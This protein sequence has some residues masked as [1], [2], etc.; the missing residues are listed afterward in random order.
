M[1]ALNMPAPSAPQGMMW[2][3][4]VQENYE[5]NGFE[6][7]SNPAGETDFQRELNLDAQI[8][9][10]EAYQAAQVRHREEQERRKSQTSRRR[11][12]FA[13]ELLLYSSNRTYQDVDCMWY[14]REELAEFK[15]ERK[16]I[17]K[18]LKKA[19]FNL[20][21]V[22]QSG[23]YCL[24]GYEAYFSME[25]N[26]A[27]KYSRTLVINVVATEQA[28][29]RKEGVYFDDE[30]MRSACSGSSQ[31]AL[32]NALLLG[33]NDEFDAYGDD[34]E[35]CSMVMEESNSNF[36]YEDVGE[37]EGSDAQHDIFDSQSYS[38]VDCVSGAR[39]DSELSPQQPQLP[40]AAA[41][42]AAA[43]SPDSNSLRPEAES[44][45][46]NLAERL[47]CAMKLVH[48]LRYG[49]SPASS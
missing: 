29:Q 8:K 40:T 31:W 44:S 39:M 32:D 1:P 6:D 23:Q 28:R 19:N 14:T 22:E 10:Y 18:V 9:A 34:G 5:M 2:E 27:M 47:E 38:S 21:A 15:N 3:V 42:S 12:R 7:P 45:D 43:A 36:Y 49:S 35:C 16:N 30:A 4:S 41:A 20:A 25:V 33:S 11:V 46:D 26:K 48:A 13:D 24:R 37:F 17:V